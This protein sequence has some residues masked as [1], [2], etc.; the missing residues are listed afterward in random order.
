[1]R[2][3]GI[4]PQLEELATGKAPDLGLRSMKDLRK[5]AVWPF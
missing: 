3:L 1:M 2:R 4:L 5:A